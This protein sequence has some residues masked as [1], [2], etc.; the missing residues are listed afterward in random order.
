MSFS[1]LDDDDNFSLTAFDQN[2]LED[3]VVN[4]TI[5]GES[6]N[7]QVR[8]SKNTYELYIRNESLIRKHQT[9]QITFPSLKRLL[10][11]LRK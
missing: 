4:D 7:F 3:M 10:G 2:K 11:F 6:G 8:R 1:Y 9:M 5:E